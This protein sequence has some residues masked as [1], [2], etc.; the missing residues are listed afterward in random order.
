[1]GGVDG[2]ANRRLLVS[3]GKFSF[4][5]ILHFFLF[6]FPLVYANII[7]R[8]IVTRLR[9]GRTVIPL[10]EPRRDST[11]KTKA[12]ILVRHPTC[13]R[14]IPVHHFAEG[15][16]ATVGTTMVLAKTDDF[17]V[18][19]HKILTV[20]LRSVV[21]DTSA[22]FNGQLRGREVVVT[23]TAHRVHKRIRART[24]QCTNNLLLLLPPLPTKECL[25]TLGRAGIPSG[26]PRTCRWKTKERNQARRMAMLKRCLHLPSLIRRR[27]RRKR[28]A[29]LV[30]PLKPRL[31]LPRYRNL[32][33]ILHRE[34]RPEN[35]PLDSLSRHL[36]VGS[37]A[38][39][40]LNSCMTSVQT[41]GTEIE[42]E[43]ETGIGIG[44]EIGIGIGTGTG[45]GIET[46]VALGI[47]MTVETS[48][49][50]QTRGILGKTIVALITARID[51]GMTAGR[52][53]GLSGV[54]SGLLKSRNQRR[55]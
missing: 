46:S 4:S 26:R 7:H 6:V 28:A 40:P 30:S 36:V 10:K 23:N 53:L 9:I 18:Q 8:Y 52:S 25:L 21:E 16:P 54:V 39:L 37:P 35:R 51:D 11:I 49:I 31:P 42:T 50:D 13:N 17:R 3:T 55:S 2:T 32:S 48:E 5:P 15:I 19:V 38:D 24:V 45:T 27:L 47:G 12:S 20:R 14:G 34:C 22:T 29:N 33:Q 43:N 44:I 1:M 41:E